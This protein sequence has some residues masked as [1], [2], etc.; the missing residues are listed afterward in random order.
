MCSAPVARV[1]HSYCVGFI[2]VNSKYRHTVASA[3]RGSACS[4][5][6]P[7]PDAMRG[8]P[9]F[10]R[11]LPEDSAEGDQ[12]FRKGS[13]F[14]HFRFVLLPLRRDRVG[15]GLPHHAPV[16]AVLLG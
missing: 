1:D 10:A 5:C 14:G 15:D 6:S 13:I 12:S 3:I 16:H 4:S 11:R 7:R 2:Q 8:V 9:L